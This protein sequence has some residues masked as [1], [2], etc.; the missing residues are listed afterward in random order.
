MNRTEST[1][2]EGPN[3]KYCSWAGPKLLF[4]RT[5]PSFEGNPNRTMLRRKV[6][7]EPC[8]EGKSEP[9]V[10]F[11]TVHN[12]PFGSSLTSDRTLP[13]RRTASLR[14]EPSLRVPPLDS[15]S[16]VRTELQLTE[17][18]PRSEELR[19]KMQFSPRFC[20]FLRFKPIFNYFNIGFSPKTLF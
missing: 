20:I 6:R 19:W 4:I 7:T 2:H 14:T 16:R 10:L 8:V 18:R 12:S 13:S 17:P 11:I 3:R 15:A 5:E 9:K 1:I